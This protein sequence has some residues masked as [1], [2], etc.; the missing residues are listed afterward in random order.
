MGTALPDEVWQKIQTDPKVSLLAVEVSQNLFQK[1]DGSFQ[2]GRVTRFHLSVRERLQDK[3]RYS[4]R[5][6]T[7]PTTSD[8]LILPLAEFPAFIYYLL[9]P[10][11]LVREQVLKKINQNF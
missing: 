8:W 1:T 4:L 6:S 5:L 2:D 10:I 9:R 3:I 11:R 7:T